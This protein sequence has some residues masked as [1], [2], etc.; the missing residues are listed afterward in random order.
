MRVYVN[1]QLKNAMLV[2]R[3]LSGN[4]WNIR[5]GATGNPSYP[6]WVNGKIDDVRIYRRALG[7]DGIQRL[8]PGY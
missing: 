5:T 6:Y 8:Y 3:T 4:T 7:A 1:G 2:S